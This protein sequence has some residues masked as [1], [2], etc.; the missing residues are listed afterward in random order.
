MNA[1]NSVARRS[2]ALLVSMI[3]GARG[4]GKWDLGPTQQASRPG[5]FHPQPLSEPCVNLS[6]HTAPIR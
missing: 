2:R 5:G 1:R 4:Y 3:G 6:T